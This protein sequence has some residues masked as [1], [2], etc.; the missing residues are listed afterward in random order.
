MVWS[1]RPLPLLAT[2]CLC[3]HY[4]SLSKKVINQETSQS[5]NFVCY[6]SGGCDWKR[7]QQ[8]FDGQQKSVSTLK[9]ITGNLFHALILP[10]TTIKQLWNGESGL[11]VYEVFYES[12]PQF[13][14]QVFLLFVIGVDQNVHSIVLTVLSMASSYISV[15]YCINKHIVTNHFQSTDCM[16]Y[17]RSFMYTFSDLHLRL[18][19]YSLSWVLL[20]EKH[21]FIYLIQTRVPWF[22]VIFLEHGDVNHSLLGLLCILSSELFRFT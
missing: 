10:W 14:F 8:S 9:I 4:F 5:S 1:V 3:H 12:F 18:I 13:V 22:L 11:K 15:V 16:D 21:N 20:N 17:V 2:T 7:N 19:V 6:S